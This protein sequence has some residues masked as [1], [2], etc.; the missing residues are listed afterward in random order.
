MEL[1]KANKLLAD[2]EEAKKTLLAEEV[3]KAREEMESLISLFDMCMASSKF[4]EARSLLDKL[5]RNGRDWQEEVAQA[6]AANIR[7]L[8]KR[9]RLV[10]IDENN[11]IHEVDY[12]LSCNYHGQHILAARTKDDK[13]LY[14]GTLYAGQNLESP[15]QTI[16]QF[17]I[18]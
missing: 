7:S 17:V 9:G 6:E 11:E 13:I 15:L 5:P 2:I 8:V 14:S 16:L 12:S 4:A 1:N 18:G 3:R 10:L